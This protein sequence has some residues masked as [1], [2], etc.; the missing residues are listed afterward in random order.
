[1]L[2]PPVVPSLFRRRRRWILLRLVGNG[3]LQAAIAIALALLVEEAFSLMI[4]SSQAPASS[5]QD[6][7]S[8]LSLM[9]SLLLLVVTRGILL[10]IETVDAERVG[11]HYVGELRD[12]LAAKVMRVSPRLLT[13]RS[14]GGSLLRFTGDLTAV[15]NWVSQGIARLLVAGTMILAV[16]AV[17]AF[18]TPVIALVLAMI[19]AL[20]GVLTLR[21]GREVDIRARESRKDRSALAANTG[22][23][24]AAGATVQAFDQTRR[25]QRRIR[26]QSRRLRESMVRRA[27]ANGSLRATADVTANLGTTIVIGLGLAI[28]PLQAV[29]PSEIVGAMTLV[30]LLVSPIRDLGRVE[31][32]RRDA[33]VAS[34]KVAE[35][36]NR[37]EGLASRVNGCELMP[38]PGAITFENVSVPSIIE[39]FTAR[40][41]P[42]TLTVI[43]GPN[44]AG[45][46]TP[47]E[48]VAGLMEPATGDIR[49][50]GQPTLRVSQSSLRQAIGIAGPQV[51]LLRGPVRRNLNYRTRDV[52]EDEQQRIREL[53]GITELLAELPKGEETQ[54]T[55][56]GANLSPGQK[57]RILLARAL[58]G[59]PRVLLL[60]EADANLDPDAVAVLGRVI[61]QFEGTVLFVTH[62]RE[63]LQHADEIWHL[64]AGR[65]VEQGSPG[66]VLDGDG[67]T[68]RLF[69]PEPI[70]LAS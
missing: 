65:L 25:E 55:D 56:G 38:G 24:L 5:G 13:S 32:Y 43:V 18:R 40:V 64:D 46:S 34:E 48:L 9:A 15:R 44:G 61:D 68:A 58:L 63:W 2:A 19:L 28:F 23:I 17:L 57:Q 39:H 67:P 33:G 49:I 10:R 16:L 35:V 30:G 60:D 26:K 29:T 1:M 54:L 14:H 47:L 42:H 50:D 6:E 12:L 4:A 20:G 36:L 37:P 70:R 11:Q 31:R 66:E 7:S 69:A 21:Y 27:R 22:Q 59:N 62:R 45:K 52:P 51:P 41:R 53:C 8:R 3:L